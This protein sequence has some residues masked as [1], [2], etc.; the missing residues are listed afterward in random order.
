MFE[1]ESGTRTISD[2]GASSDVTM[3]TA[4]DHVTKYQE[5]IKRLEFENKVLHGRIRGYKTLGEF[6]F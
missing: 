1:M 6:S 5:Q 2:E 3:S 4:T